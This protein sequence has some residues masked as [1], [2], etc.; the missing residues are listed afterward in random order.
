MRV[1]A[2]YSHDSPEHIE[3][4]LQLADDLRRAGAT[5]V[6]DSLAGAPPEG[7]PAWA[8]REIEGADA[9]VIVGSPTYHRNYDTPPRGNVGRGVS[10]EAHIIRQLLYDGPLEGKVF[11]VL[12]GD[13]DPVDSIPVEL[14]RFSRFRYPDELGALLAALEQ[15]GGRLSRP[16]PLRL[17]WL[18]SAQR[19]RLVWL[20]LPI[21]W[22]A[23]AGDLSQLDT[24]LNLGAGGLVG[25]V[26]A[27]D[28]LVVGFE[29]STPEQ[30][31]RAHAAVIDA[32]V[33]QGA[34]AVGVDVLFTGDEP[35]DEVL[36]ASIRRAEGA[37]V[38]VV[39]AATRVNGTIP[40]LPAR[41]A[42]AVR[43]RGGADMVTAWWGLVNVGFLASEPQADGVLHHMAPALLAAT[44]DATPVLE[45]GVLRIGPFRNAA[46]SALV[47]APRVE[48]VPTLQYGDDLG[49]A[50]SRVVFLGALGP[51]DTKHTV[52][53]RVPGVE[54]HARMYQVLAS[55]RAV[56]VLG[57]AWDVTV[58][59][60][61]TALLLVLAP[62]MRRPRQAALLVAAA[63]VGAWLILGC[64]SQRWF[65]VS[66]AFILIVAWYYCTRRHAR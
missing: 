50:R 53:D 45:A 57:P 20:A 9:V 55:Q 5:V 65:S 1:F 26:P 58:A 12:C 27:T 47:L 32:L 60:G 63:W 31:R 39:V 64:S 25:A 17:L 3:T 34:R 36:A 41:L 66:S 22:A 10:W 49:S 35:A 59:A 8:R 40:P 62:R 61:A 19:A 43:R 28:V 18:R 52:W 14:R 30:E 54:L 46:R 13:L 4:V 51:E 7:W 42:P 11:P 33:A 16:S 56:R 23:V 15:V 48:R 2:S 38:P 44:M 29:R 21:A 6:L 24:V 37:G